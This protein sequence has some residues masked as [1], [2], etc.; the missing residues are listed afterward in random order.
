[1]IISNSM[2]RHKIGYWTG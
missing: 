1:M 2:T